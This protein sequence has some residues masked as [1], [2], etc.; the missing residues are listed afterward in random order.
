MKTLLE[1]DSNTLMAA[2]PAIVFFL[3]M[4]VAFGVDHYLI[5]RRAK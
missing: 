1:L 2:S 4:L 3:V 5:N